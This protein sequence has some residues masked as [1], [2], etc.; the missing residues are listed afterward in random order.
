[1]IQIC[2]DIWNKFVSIIVYRKISINHD[3]LKYI[4]VKLHAGGKFGHLFPLDP[5]YISA[6]LIMRYIAVSSQ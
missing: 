1:M 6:L 2:H 5:I 3:L 4:V